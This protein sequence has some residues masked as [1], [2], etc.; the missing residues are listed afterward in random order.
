ML[1]ICDVKINTIYSSFHVTYSYV[2]VNDKNFWNQDIFRENPTR[3]SRIWIS[4]KNDKG[5][6][7]KISTPWFPRKSVHLCTSSCFFW[8]R[9]HPLLI[10]AYARV[11]IGLTSSICSCSFQVHN[12]SKN[13][14]Y[15]RER[16]TNKYSKLNEVRVTKLLVNCQLLS[17]RKIIS[18]TKY[19]PNL[20]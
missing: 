14:R 7:S 16:K 9:W 11:K 4:D 1:F 10:Y 17:V 6:F 8:M 12:D 3:N 19:I 5:S 18:I 15:S 2:K 13:L 20:L